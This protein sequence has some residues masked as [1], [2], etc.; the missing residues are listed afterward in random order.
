MSE[1]TAPSM[2]VDPSEKASEAARR[3]A[4]LVSEKGSAAAERA[5]QAGR[6]MARS[7]GERLKSGASKGGRLA[8]AKLTQAGM[9]LTEKQHQALERIKDKVSDS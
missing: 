3:A 6:R 7:V 1:E 8:I 2:T 5:G 9:K 4:R